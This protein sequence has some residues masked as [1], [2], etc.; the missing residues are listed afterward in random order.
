MLKSVLQHT[1]TKMLYIRHPIYPF[2]QIVIYDTS[3]KNVFN[4]TLV[5]LKCLHSVLHNFTQFH[6]TGL[7]L[8]CTQRKLFTD[9]GDFSVTGLI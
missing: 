5:T 4:V 9:T 6:N 8:N 3:L 1:S 2:R 7:C